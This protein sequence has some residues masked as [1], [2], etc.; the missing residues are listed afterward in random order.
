[1]T[2]EVVSS[3]LLS[4][5]TAATLFVTLTPDLT[6]IRKAT[7]TPTM[8]ND[9]RL[10]VITASCLALAIGVTAAS[11]THSP[12]PALLS[13]G[14]CIGLYLTYESVLTATPKENK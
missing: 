13:V 1:M 3:S 11:L 2:P 14:M 9:V 6:D 7:A 5:T 10:G 12:I 4:L 8:V